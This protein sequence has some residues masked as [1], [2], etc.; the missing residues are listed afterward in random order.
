M[1]SRQ[2]TYEPQA[3]WDGRL[4]ARWDLTGVGHVGYSLRYNRWLY[5]AQGRVLAR[6]LRRAG[7][8]PADRSV[9]DVG[10]G[11]GH[12]LDWY[13]KRGAGPL[14][15]L[16]LSPAAAGRLRERF[17]QATVVEGNIAEAPLENAAFDLV[18]ILGVIYHLVEPA[19]FDRALANLA[20]L[21]APGGRLVLSDT[22]GQ[23][24]KRPAA[25][26]RFRP[27]KLYEER[28]PSLG[29]QIEVVEPV[30]VLLN[31]GLSAA[32][33]GVSRGVK[34]RV[35]KWVRGGEEALAPILYMLDRSPGLGR[36]AN[37]RMM[38]AKKVSR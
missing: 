26:V 33:R 7:A 22:L 21:T 19:T 4:A 36:H 27:L 29:F 10:S 34:P 17:P 20:R 12:W 25:H 35:R 32:A 3:Y 18:N 31:G 5:R 1:T 13:A 14:T 37:M 11:T 24:E 30:Y 8:A 2:G 9:L 38:V 15:G 16:E 6:A 28:L 23:C